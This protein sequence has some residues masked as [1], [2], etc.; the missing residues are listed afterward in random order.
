[1]RGLRNVKNHAIVQSESADVWNIH[2]KTKT[3]FI[4]NN[5]AKPLDHLLLFNERRVEVLVASQK[6]DIVYPLLVHYT[7][8]VESLT[9]R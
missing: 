9:D 5:W 4:S 1:M 7:P 2:D 3:S 6:A 8:P